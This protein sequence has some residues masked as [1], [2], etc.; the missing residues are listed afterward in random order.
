MY[1]TPQSCNKLLLN[2]YKKIENAKTEE[3]RQRLIVEYNTKKI[4]YSIIVNNREMMEK[5]G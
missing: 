1:P 5:L 3:E 4:A 2:I